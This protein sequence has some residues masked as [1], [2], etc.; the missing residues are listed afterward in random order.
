MPGN[1][2]H[3]YGISSTP[4]IGKDIRFRVTHRHDPC[5]SILINCFGLLL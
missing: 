2:P 3:P 5:M 4:L 1:I